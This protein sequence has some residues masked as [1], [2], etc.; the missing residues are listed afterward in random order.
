MQPR[1]IALAA[2]LIGALPV[3]YVLGQQNAAPDAAEQFGSLY[4]HA[5]NNPELLDQLFDAY[6]KLPGDAA[7]TKEAVRG[8]WVDAKK[9][10]NSAFLIIQTM[11]NQK[12]IEQNEKLIQQNAHIAE[13]LEKNSKK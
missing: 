10:D 2:F 8:G 3:T 13:L 12:I 6:A 1:K 9:G 5:K 7:V 4:E 11:Q